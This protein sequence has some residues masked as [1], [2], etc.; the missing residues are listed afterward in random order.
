MFEPMVTCWNI[1]HPDP[2]S[3]RPEMNTPEYPCGK[4]GRDLNLA[5]RLISHDSTL[6]LKRYALPN[7]GL[8]LSSLSFQKSIAANG[9]E[10]SPNNLSPNR[11]IQP[12]TP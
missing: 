7:T 10:T 2:I 1:T 8:E 5:V 3:A 12:G 6:C 4:Q 11:R 9:R